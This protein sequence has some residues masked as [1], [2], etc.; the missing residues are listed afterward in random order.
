MV[1]GDTEPRA[2]RART[3]DSQLEPQN[4]EM[5]RRKSFFTSTIHVGLLEEPR[6]SLHQ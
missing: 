5:L 2:A 4:Q 3:A 1:A 6:A